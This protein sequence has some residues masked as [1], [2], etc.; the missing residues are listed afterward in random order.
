MNFPGSFHSTS[1]VMRD[2]YA[3]FIL[4]LSR[5]GQ[6]WLSTQVKKGASTSQVKV[7]D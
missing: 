1:D 2:L 6:I 4:D 3:N 5:M 7:S